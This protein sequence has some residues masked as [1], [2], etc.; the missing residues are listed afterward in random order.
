VPGL[1]DIPAENMSKIAD[2]L[3][4]V[5]DALMIRYCRFC[6]YYIIYLFAFS[7][8]TPL[9]GRQEGHPACKKLNGGVMAW[10]S[11]WS[12]VQTCRADATATHCLLLQ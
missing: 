2:A 3:E 1:R 11:V 8:L 12:K 9:V 4:E 7:S 10:L 6:L 5:S